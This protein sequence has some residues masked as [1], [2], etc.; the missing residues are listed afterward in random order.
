[1]MNMFCQPT[2]RRERGA[3]NSQK[4]P[5]PARK[6]VIAQRKCAADDA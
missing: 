3:K 5:I 4:T 1:M 6:S 2:Q